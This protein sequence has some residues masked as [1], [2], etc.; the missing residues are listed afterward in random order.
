MWW[1]GQSQ[2]TVNL[3]AVCL[4]RFESYRP[5]TSFAQERKAIGYK[6]QCPPPAGRKTMSYFVYVLRSKKDGKL[7]T[8][9]SEDPER[10]LKEHN[11][12][13]TVSLLKRRP[14][15]IVYQEI[16]N[17]EIQAKRRERFLKTGQGRKFLQTAL[18]LAVVQDFR[19][20]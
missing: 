15:I 11:A 6:T 10:R 1:S 8:G 4:R 18:K 2:Q 7:Y 13:K 16:Y 9:Y 17:K 5:H 3:S 19:K 12:G 20:N 14:L